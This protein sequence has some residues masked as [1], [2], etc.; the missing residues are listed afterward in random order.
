MPGVLFSGQG[1]HRRRLQVLSS[2]EEMKLLAEQ[3][4]KARKERLLQVKGSL[5][6]IR[7]CTWDLHFVC[8]QHP[9]SWRF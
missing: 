9:S 7:V 5:P 3:R 4:Y 6:R 1:T 2:E 8:N